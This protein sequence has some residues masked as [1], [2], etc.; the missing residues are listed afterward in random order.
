MQLVLDACKFQSRQD[1]AAVPWDEIAADA[2]PSSK[3]AAAA[4]PSGE[5]TADAA[6]PSDEAPLPRPRSRL[7]R[8]STGA[9]A[10]SLSL[11]TPKSGAGRLP[12]D[13]RAGRR[14]RRLATAPP[15]FSPPATRERGRAAIAHLTLALV[16]FS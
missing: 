11:R 16:P 1:G 3:D 8:E 14:R 6:P 15:S 4:L 5:A 9:A 12:E 2:P 7:E 10:P 13:A